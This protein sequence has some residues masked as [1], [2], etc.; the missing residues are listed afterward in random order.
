MNLFGEST[1]R[2][3]IELENQSKLKNVFEP[4]VYDMKNNETL[5]IG[6]ERIWYSLFHN[7]IN[8]L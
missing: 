2:L 1:F 7:G 3:E 6:K 5:Q 8:L 4:A